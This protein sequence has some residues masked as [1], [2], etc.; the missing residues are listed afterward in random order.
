[1][2]A[3][4]G[5]GIVGATKFV[6]RLGI[7]AVGQ[8]LVGQLQRLLQGLLL[9]GGGGGEPRTCGNLLRPGGD[10]LEVSDPLQ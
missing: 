5:I 7:V 2:K 8:D 1:M 3:A 4:A 10:S 6:A 9:P